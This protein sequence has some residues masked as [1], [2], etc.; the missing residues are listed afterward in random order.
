MCLQSVLWQNGLLDPDAIR[1]VSGVGRGMGVLD[2]GA[3]HRREGA[4]LGVNLAVCGF[5][6]IPGSVRYVG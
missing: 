6:L 2:G 5:L 4:V 3:N 1:M